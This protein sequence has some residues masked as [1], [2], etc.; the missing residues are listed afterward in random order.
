MI[1]DALDWGGFEF[2]KVEDFLRL[3]SLGL[4][5]CRSK[6]DFEDYNSG[7]ITDVLGVPTD[8]FGWRVS[9]A[10]GGGADGWYDDMRSEYG[11][12]VCDVAEFSGLSEDDVVQLYQ[13]GCLLAERSLKDGELLFPPIQFEDV[14]E[15]RR[16]SPEFFECAKILTRGGFGGERGAHFLFFPTTNYG[17]LTAAELLKT[18]DDGLRAMVIAD[19]HNYVLNTYVEKSANEWVEVTKGSVPNPAVV[20]AFAGSGFLDDSMVGEPDGEFMFSDV[21]RVLKMSEGLM[22]AR[23]QR[24]RWGYSAR[25]GHGVCHTSVARALGLPAED[26]VSLCKSGEL[27][28]LDV[29]DIDDDFEE[30]SSLEYTVADFHLLREGSWEEGIKVSLCPAS[31]RLGRALRE[32]GWSPRGIASFMDS[33]SPWFGVVPPIRYARLGEEYEAAVVAVAAA[34]PCR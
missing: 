24:G 4:K 26:V 3:R 23:S 27:V 28:V 7:L 20:Q 25:W 6:C 17:L 21:S 2:P 15:T 10:F 8:W 19:T 30:A 9:N 14:D 11:F 5:D 34:L 31:V 13:E 1:Y 12:K 32:L 33:P 29:Q 16:I 18:G 22:L